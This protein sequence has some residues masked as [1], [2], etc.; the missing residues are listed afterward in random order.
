MQEA[1]VRLASAG[2]GQVAAADL[3]NTSLL[4]TPRLSTAQSSSVSA[5]PASLHSSRHVAS[6]SSVTHDDFEDEFADE[7]PLPAATELCRALYDFDGSQPGSLAITKGEQLEIVE[8]D[9]SGEQWTKV[10]RAATAQIGFVPTQYISIES[11]I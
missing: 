5:S 4:G 1:N 8:R 10:C 6:S 7:P 3:N 2:G 11:S 9:P